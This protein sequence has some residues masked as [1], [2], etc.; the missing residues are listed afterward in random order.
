MK[1][2]IIAKAF[3]FAAVL[4]M[5]HTGAGA[6]TLELY[7]Q[8]SKG[9][10]NYI[11]NL[12]NG[13]TYGASWTGAQN[14]SLAAD[15]SNAFWAYCIDPMTTTKWASGTTNLNVY[16]SAS[17]NSFLNTV[18]PASGKTGYQ[19]EMSSGGYT[20]LA[21]GIQTASLVENSLVSLF[22]HAYADSLTS[23]TKAAAFGY[24]VWEII[25]QSAYSRTAGALRSAG[26]DGTS[27]AVGSGSRDTLEV[28]IDAYL[29]ALTSNSWGS[30][31]GT[32]LTAATNYLYTV[33]FDPNPHNAQNFLS[34]TNAPPVGVPEPGSLALAGLALVG[35]YGSRRRFIGK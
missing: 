9:N 15:G 35:A 13:T 34:V 27:Y 12:N 5:A 23:N 10:T 7:Q 30:V 20:G 1:L 18:L 31:N 29:T 16:T 4:A 24:A 26:S 22:S 14:I 8:S 11:N 3:G 32:N 25:G 2:S 19:E 17:L 6:Q 28:Q 33:Y 21:Y